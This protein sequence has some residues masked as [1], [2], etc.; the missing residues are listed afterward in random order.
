[1]EGVQKQ[2]EALIPCQRSA[3]RLLRVACYNYPPLNAARPRV[4]SK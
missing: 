4:A 2:P 1:M 3:S